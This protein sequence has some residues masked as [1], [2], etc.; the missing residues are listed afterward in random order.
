MDF[1][2]LLGLLLPIAAASGWFAAVRSQANQAE[3]SQRK[4]ST[5]YLKGLNYLLNEQQ[6]KAMDVFIR[7]LEVD[8]ETYETHLALGVWFRRKGEMNRAIRIHQHLARLPRLT[9]ARRML[10]NLE[11][12]LDYHHAGLLDRA[13]ALFQE[14]AKHPDYEHI[15]CRHLL[16]IYQQERDWEKSIRI[17]QRLDGISEE[18]YAPI[19]A[20]YYCELA[21]QYC[22]QGD[23]HQAGAML[24]LALRTDPSCVRASLEE[25]RLAL[26]REDGAAA[27]RAFKRVEL[28]DNRYL[29]EAIPPL[30]ACYVRDGKLDE[31]IEYLRYVLKKYGGITPMLAL[32]SLLKESSGEQA[33]A[34]F[35]LKHLR[36]RPSVRGLDYFLDIT[37]PSAQGAARENLLALKEISMELLHNKPIYRCNQCGFQGKTLYWQCPWCRNWNTIQPIQGVEGE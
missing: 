33:A 25:G 3:H 19:V 37:L 36:I 30:H 24:E 7:L 28:Q 20:Q 22:R 32:A 8:S 29:A 17:A 13:E 23:V 1:T 15:A 31:F 26:A 5:Q 34:E 4:L 11:L 18:D 10:A 35:V 27:V 12:G 14:S 2:L 16:E 21:D 9:P 6:D